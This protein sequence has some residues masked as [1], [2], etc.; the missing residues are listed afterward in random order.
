MLVRS[1]GAQ[2]GAKAGVSW[3]R[4]HGITGL[5]LSHWWVK[6]F[7]GAISNPVVSGIGF[8]NLLL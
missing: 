3:T 2:W 8:L 6:P 4:A 1:I 7:P 5:V